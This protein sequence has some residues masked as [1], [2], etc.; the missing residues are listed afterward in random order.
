M[1]LKDQNIKKISTLYRFT[2]RSFTNSTRHN[3]SCCDLPCE[4]M[5]NIYETY[6]TEFSFK[7]L[8]QIPLVDIGGRL[9]QKSA[10]S[11]YGTV[12]FQITRAVQI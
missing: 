4:Q 12:A 8:G 3:D 9:G 1:F 6:Q 2:G 11:E 7:G 10:F 5:Y